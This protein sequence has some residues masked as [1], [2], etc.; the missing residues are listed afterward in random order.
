MTEH[1]YMSQLAAVLDSDHRGLKIKESTYRGSWKK[2]GGVG[3]AMMVLRKVD[4]LENILAQSGYDIFSMIARNP[5]SGDGTALAEVRDLRR[6]L[7]LVEAEMVARGVVVIEGKPPTP[8]PDSL[9]TPRARP[10]VRGLLHRPPKPGTPEDGGHHAVLMDRVDDGLTEPP[11][12]PYI[13]VRAP[14]GSRRY[15]V[16]RREFTI[17][18]VEHLPLLDRE[19]N[20]KEWKETPPHYQSMYNWDNNADK[21]VLATMYWDHWARQ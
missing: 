1:D 3:A 17:D 7:A 9:G 20:H 8:P 12:Y 11:D 13:T 19:L 15:I 2:R 16:D 21:W 5:S 6:Y 4:R 10:Y 18:D 14:D